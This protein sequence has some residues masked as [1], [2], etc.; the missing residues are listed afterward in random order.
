MAA[1]FMAG[2]AASTGGMAPM[3]MAQEA[4]A[5]GVDLD[6]L[7]RRWHKCV[8]QAFSGQPAGLATHAAQKAALAECKSLENSYVS[9]MLVAQAAEAEARRQGKP[10]LG[11][12]ARGWATSLLSY[13]VE[14]VTSWIDAW[15]R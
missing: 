3:A 15:R 8:R 13:V 4:P 11:A 2:L 7:E 5:A 12:R 10:S 6:L 1:A 9:A 14:P